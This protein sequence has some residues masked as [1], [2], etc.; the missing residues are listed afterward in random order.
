MYESDEGTGILLME[1]MVPGIP[2]SESGLDDA[3][4]MEI[5]MN[6]AAQFAPTWREGMIPISKYIE[7]ESKL[8]EQLLA[9]TEREVF[10]HGDLHHFNIL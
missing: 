5:A 2:L 3:Q 9:T 1:R 7:R 6:L 4:N 10:L 8:S